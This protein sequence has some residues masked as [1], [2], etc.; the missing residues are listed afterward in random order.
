MGKTKT[1]KFR[2][3]SRVSR[4]DKR[5]YNNQDV[6]FICKYK[7]IGVIFHTKGGNCAHLEMSKIKEIIYLLFLT[8]ALIFTDMNK[9]HSK[10]LLLLIGKK[11]NMHLIV[12]LC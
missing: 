8:F 11:P 3:G 1:V 10:K 5:I 6:V 4:N 9:M 12:I 2:R 7:L